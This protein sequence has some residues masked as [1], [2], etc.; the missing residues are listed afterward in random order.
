MKHWTRMALLLA[1]MPIVASAQFK[2]LDSAML[3]LREELEAKYDTKELD[4]YDSPLREGW[5]GKQTS[6]SSPYTGQK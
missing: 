3:K 2:D 4:F 6:S 5:N 1:F